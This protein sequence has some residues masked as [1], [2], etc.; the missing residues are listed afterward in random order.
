VGED[1]KSPE[2]LVNG[3][4]PARLSLTTSHSTETPS[5]LSPPPAPGKLQATISE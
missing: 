3:V 1:M 4:F 5:N 2:E